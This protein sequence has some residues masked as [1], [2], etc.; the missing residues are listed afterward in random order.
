[1]FLEVTMRSVLSLEVTMHHKVQTLGFLGKKT[2]KLCCFSR[3]HSK[4]VTKG[5]SQ[6]FRLIFCSFCG[7]VGRGPGPC[8]RG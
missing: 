5:L 8:V 4:T 7:T 1:M 3:S 6:A 2:E